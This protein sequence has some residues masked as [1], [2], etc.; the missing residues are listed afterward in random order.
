EVADY[1]GPTTGVDMYERYSSLVWNAD[2]SVLAFMGFDAEYKAALAIF[3]RQDQTFTELIK[4]VEST[5]PVSFT[6]D[7][8]ILFGVASGEFVETQGTGGA[9]INVMTVSP[10][11]GAA[12]VMIG[13][14]VLGVGCGGG[15]SIP[16]DWRYWT[17]SQ[18][19]PGVSNQIL[20]L[21][22]FGLVHSQNC[23]GVG[24]ALLDFATNTDTP[25]GNNLAWARVSPDGTRVAG[26]SYPNSYVE[27][28]GESLVTVDLAT[29]TNIPVVSAPGVSQVIWGSNTSLIYSTRTDTGQIFPASA[30]DQ[31]KVGEAIG[32]MTPS[33]LPLFAVTIQQLDLTTGIDTP[34]YAADAYAIG[35][36]GV[37]ADGTT[38]MFSQIPNLNAFVEAVVSGTLTDPAQTVLVEAN[39]MDLAASDLL[40]TTIGAGINQVTVNPVM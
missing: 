31:Q 33:T 4:P 26:I 40:P 27:L 34:L 18:G 16:A 2:G 25:L 8:Q 29:K 28:G 37:S 22:P 13:S 35:R 11:P 23:T 30:E 7:G 38:L 19:G 39:I 14:Y 21:T 15:S 10:T 32:A 1:V 20:A 6:A 24:T 9:V 3:N 17:E 36:M 5:L 12:P